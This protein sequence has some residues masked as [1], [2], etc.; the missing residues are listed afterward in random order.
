MICSGKVAQLDFLG[1]VEVGFGQGM[2]A[3]RS[4]CTVS[5]LR[6]RIYAENAKTAQ[7]LSQIDPGQALRWP[8]A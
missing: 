8:A 2:R 4:C 7:A 5:A 1:Q 6:D 3:V